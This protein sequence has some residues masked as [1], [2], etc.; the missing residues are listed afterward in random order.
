[1]L[2]DIFI[3]DRVNQIW[4]RCHFDKR[5]KR[6]ICTVYG[7]ISQF[8]QLLR[9]QSLAVDVRFFS[10]LAAHLSFVGTIKKGKNSSKT[11]LR[12]NFSACLREN[13]PTLLHVCAGTVPSRGVGRSI[14][15]LVQ[16]PDL[17]FAFGAVCEGGETKHTRINHH[18]S[19]ECF[20]RGKMWVLPCVQSSWNEEK[21]PGGS[22]S[23]RKWRGRE[24]ENASIKILRPDQ[25]R[26]KK[27]W[28]RT[29]YCC[30][31]R[32]KLELSNFN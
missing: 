8:S 26:G 4:Q 31:W 19:S 28:Y 17:P 6:K 5:Q 7:K 16:L 18:P 10:F 29:A 11:S 1:M 32:L 13:N 3:K 14:N 22:S 21:I 23:L 12:W 27:I 30:F 15:F 20:A 2:A 25:G 9:L 24:E